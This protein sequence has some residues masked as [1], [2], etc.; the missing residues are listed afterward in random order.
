MAVTGATGSLFAGA[1]AVELAAAALALHHQT[2][3]GSVNFATPADGACLALSSRP[4]GGTLT[5]AMS[6]AFSIG[7]QSGA[8]VLRRYQP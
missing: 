4:R 2:L 7:G 5:H 8:C 6:G 1:G 3:P